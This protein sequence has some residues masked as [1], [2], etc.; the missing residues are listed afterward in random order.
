MNDWHTFVQWEL[1]S[2]ETIDFKMIYVDVA[3]GDI[4]AGLL[5][6]QIIFW[7]LPG[8]DG[9]SKLRVQ[10]ENKQKENKFWLARKHC[11]WYQEIRMSEDQ[12][13]RAL[14]VLKELNF[15]EVS[16]FRFNGERITHIALNKNVLAH[17]VRKAMQAGLIP[18]GNGINP[19]SER[20]ITHPRT[21]LNPLPLTETTTEITTE[22]LNTPHTPQ[23]GQVCETKQ[24]SLLPV[25]VEET[26]AVTPKTKKKPKEYTAAFLEFWNLY[27]EQES[28]D[29]AF[30]AWKKLNP[31]QELQ[32]TILKDIALRLEN[33][34][35][36]IGGYIP[37]PAKYLKEKRWES[38]IK[39]AQQ[40]SKPMSKIE[41]SLA[42][43]EAY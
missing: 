30:A 42:I 10:K 6:S 14:G 25:L 34:S 4:L 7:N 36:W 5:L 18:L 26:K 21:G 37:F 39:Q 20:D 41:R 43:L 22:I 33:D 31:D 19:T 1:A 8:K 9:R 17:A 35:R 28:Q 16:A 29:S 12:V 32:D 23:G 13:R 2:R 38:P 40:R 11:D 15:V 24:I 27:P 3:G